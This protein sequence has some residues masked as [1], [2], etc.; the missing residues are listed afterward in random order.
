[1]KPEVIAILCI[2]LVFV[3]I[4]IFFTRFFSKPDQK[5]GDGWVEFVST[6]ALT[7]FTQP[8]ILAMAYAAS[9][10]LIPQYQDA[11]KGINIFAGIALFL[12]FDDM[13]Q[14]WWH[15]TSHKVEWLYNLHRPHHN[16]GYMSVRLVYRNNLFYYLLMPAI[17]A[18][19]VLIYLGLGWIYAGYIVFKLLVISAAHSDIRWDRIFLNRPALAPI[20]WFIQRTISTPS[21]HH[22]HHGKYKADGITNYHGNYGNLLFFWDILFSTAKISQDYPKDYGVENLPETT[23][24]EQLLWPLVRVK[25][26]PEATNSAHHS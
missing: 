2:F 13:V 23:V 6:I 22:A 16:A 14:Y 24:A 18:S 5:K 3:I 11:L 1:M 12:I 21:T 17:W 20:W 4:E 25:A 7:G 19:G 10:A 26:D 8:F 9:L 15:R